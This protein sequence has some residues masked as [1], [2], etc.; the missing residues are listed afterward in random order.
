MTLVA[1]GGVQGV[2]IVGGGVPVG[3]AS[4]GVLASRGRVLCAAAP[5]VTA[6]GVQGV[7]VGGGG[8]PVGR[9]SAGVLARRSGALC[10]RC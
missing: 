9:A 2:M 4:G 7:M 10:T 3:R 6:G 5:L 8:V 1:A